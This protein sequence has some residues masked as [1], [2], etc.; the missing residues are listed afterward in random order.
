MMF[1]CGKNKY[2]VVVVVIKSLGE[3]AIDVLTTF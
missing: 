2:V 1:T 3:C